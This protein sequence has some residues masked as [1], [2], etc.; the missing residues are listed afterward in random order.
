MQE[1]REPLKTEVLLDGEYIHVDREWWPERWEI[2]RRVDAVAAIPITPDQDVVLV[3]QFRFAVRKKMLEIP[4]G[5]LDEEG[6]EPEACIARELFDETGY[7]HTSMTKLCGIY[8]SPGS[9]TEYVH[10]F[11]ARVDA[12]PEGKP[13]A[14]IEVVLVPFLEAVAE[15]RAGR[16]ED[17][18]TAL[19]LLLADAR[20]PS[21]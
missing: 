3:R 13:E 8:P 11:L 4:A 14:G 1:P 18:K 16:I 15:A 10:L 12:E 21:G 17:A 19:A 20:T 7:R 9:W 5:L 6:E 2:V